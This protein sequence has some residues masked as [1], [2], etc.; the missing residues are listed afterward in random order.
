MAW[1][2]P[3]ARTRVARSVSDHSCGIGIDHEAFFPSF[4]ITAFSITA[5]AIKKL[6]SST[7]LYC[8][9]DAVGAMTGEW[10]FSGVIPGFHVDDSLVARF[11]LL[12]FSVVEAEDCD[13][14]R[15]FG[16]VGKMDRYPWCCGFSLVHER[17]VNT[18]LQKIKRCA[19][20]S[21]A[22]AYEFVTEQRLHHMYK[23]PQPSS[24]QNI[25]HKPGGP[26]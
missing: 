16:I 17:W 5:F 14:E 20:S 26:S 24:R 7:M 25:L 2:S 4:S 19:R 3:L 8:R 9:L 10:C 22:R 18:I 6:S 15:S 13:V 23:N 12:G 1:R 11:D 21:S